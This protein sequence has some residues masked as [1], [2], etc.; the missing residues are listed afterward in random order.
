MDVSG[1]EKCYAKGGDAK[2]ATQGRSEL[3]QVVSGA[4]ILDLFLGVGKETL[5]SSDLLLG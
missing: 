4:E 5:L 3:T 2:A 1:A